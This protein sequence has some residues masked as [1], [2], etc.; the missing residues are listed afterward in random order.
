ML[1]AKRRQR[2]QGEIEA[3]FLAQQVSPTHLS[4]LRSL[5]FRLSQAFLQSLSSLDL[6]DWQLFYVGAVADASL[7]REVVADFS[8]KMSLCGIS[9]GRDLELAKSLKWLLSSKYFGYFDEV[10][11][12]I[13]CHR[14]GEGT[15]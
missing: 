11:H 10:R 5:H 6:K 12:G 14:E 15:E 2:L 4:T 7:S 9:N 8:V 3:N 13:T 1:R